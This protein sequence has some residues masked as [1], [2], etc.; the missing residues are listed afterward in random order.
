M[1]EG[2]AGR[3]TRSGEQKTPQASRVT[4]GVW[5]ESWSSP[6]GVV[7]GIR[8]L[9]PTFGSIPAG[10]RPLDLESIRSGRVSEDL[11]LRLKVPPQFDDRGVVLSSDIFL[12]FRQ[13]HAVGISDLLRVINDEGHQRLPQ[14]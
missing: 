1:E 6:A 11:P 2:Y 12:Q 7:P 13:V 5:P 3:P 10:P 4:C 8:N 9:P 14:V